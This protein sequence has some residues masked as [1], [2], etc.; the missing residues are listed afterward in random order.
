MKQFDLIVFDWDGTLMDS[1]GVIVHSIQAACR[2]LGIAVPDDAACRY[3]IG[4]GLGEALQR[5][6]PDLPEANYPKLVERYRHHYLI[7]D[8][9]IPL[10]AGAEQVVRALRDAGY[11]LGVATGK[12]RKGL[13]RVLTSTGLGECFHATRCADECFS[14]PHPEM[15]EQLMDELGVVPERTLMVGDTIHDLQMANQA[16]VAALAVS[17]GA[18]ETDALLAC[19][20]RACV[21]SIEELDQWLQT[22]A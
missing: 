13:D 9:T 6:L 19:A 14:K 3:I 5:L 12:S 22:C 20:P 15:L 21:N 7:E 18:H 11:L 16:R 1:A 2:D 8:Q 4:L 10:F 17:Y